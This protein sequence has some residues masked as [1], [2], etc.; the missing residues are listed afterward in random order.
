MATLVCEYYAEVGIR[1]KLVAVGKAAS[2]GSAEQ[3]LLGSTF[4]PATLMRLPRTNRPGGQFPALAMF[5]FPHG[6]RL[7]THEEAMANAIPVVT[8]FVLTAED[9]SR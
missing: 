2:A 8:S 3:A 9:K 1:E 7:V 5:T 6:A 4:E